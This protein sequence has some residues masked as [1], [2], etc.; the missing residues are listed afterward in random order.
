MP[1]VYFVAEHRRPCPAVCAEVNRIAHGEP[2]MN[3]VDLA[4]Y[5][6]V[7]VAFIQIDRRLYDI[8]KTLRAL[9]K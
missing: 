8:V 9:T 1:H 3:P 5:A 7:I 2:A 4:F 6:I